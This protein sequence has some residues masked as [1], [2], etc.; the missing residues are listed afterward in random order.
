MFGSLFEEE[1]AVGLLASAQNKSQLPVPES[2]RN[3]TGLAGIANQGATCFLN[4]TLQVLAF[5][6]E[7]RRMFE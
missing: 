7:L 2:P 3:A 1:D 6:P 5:T 4:C